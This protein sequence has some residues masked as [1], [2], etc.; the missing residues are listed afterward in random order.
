MAR[1]VGQFTRSEDSHANGHTSGTD[2]GTPG[3]STRPRPSSVGVFTQVR[4]AGSPPGSPGRTTRSAT[5][6]W[7]GSAA[8]QE[9]IRASA[10]TT[11]CPMEFP[12]RQLDDEG[13][14][15]CGR[16]DTCAGPRFAAGTSVT[17]VGAARSDPGRAGVEVE[18]R[19]VRPTELPAIGIDL[20]G[21]I[22]AGGQAAA[23]RAPGR[24]P[25][26]G[27][28]NRTASAPRPPGAGHCR[29][30]RRGAGRG[31][32]SGRLGEGPRRPGFRRL[33]HPGPAGG[34]RHGGLADPACADPF[35]GFPD[36]RD[37]PAALCSAPSSTPRTCRG[38]RAATARSG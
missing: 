24:L 21:R 7:P 37:R 2:Q 36:R 29:A 9:G 6:G 4:V 22:P 20:K 31:G 27:R 35:P 25:D 19:R 8:A 38:C 15:P 14:Q 32:C 1:T 5:T 11:E 16:C 18:P 30:G 33:R 12:R 3:R 26:I 13:A 28:G 10:S 34:C 17:A 23:G